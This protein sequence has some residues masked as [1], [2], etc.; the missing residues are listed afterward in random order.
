MGTKN[1]GAG[2][3]GVSTTLEETAESDA[4]RNTSKKKKS[5][6]SRDMSRRIKNE[7]T[8]AITSASLLHSACHQSWA[9]RV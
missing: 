4:N 7:D 9:L 8:S 3:V 2:T 5:I 6:E 1:L